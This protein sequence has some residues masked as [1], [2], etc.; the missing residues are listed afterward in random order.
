M[1]MISGWCPPF[2]VIILGVASSIIRQPSF[3]SLTLNTCCLFCFVVCEFFRCSPCKGWLP[4]ELFLVAAWENHPEFVRMF[5]LRFIPLVQ[6]RW[7]TARSL[8]LSPC[9]Q[10]HNLK[11]SHPFGNGGEPQGG[12]K[13]TE[14]W[15]YHFLME[16]LRVD[17]QIN[18]Y[19]RL[20][21]NCP[22][23]TQQTSHRSLLGP[24][25]DSPRTSPWGISSRTCARFWSQQQLLRAFHWIWI[26]KKLNI[27]VFNN[28]ERLSYKIR[29][30]LCCTPHSCL[31]R[32]K[33][34]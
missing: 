6:I 11:L 3:F 1:S 5:N 12:K 28:S 8:H 15:K 10:C 9:H 2:V 17:L 7:M 24:C 29:L 21:T 4:R 33:L 34:N 20:L 18:F 27:G 30:H 23:R 16:E 13:L 31:I 25:F 26:K 22:L 19:F 32:L 14:G